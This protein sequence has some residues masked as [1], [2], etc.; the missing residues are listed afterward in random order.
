M[1]SPI[2]PTNDQ[3]S[4]LNEAS[5][6]MPENLQYKILDSNTIEINIIVPIYGVCIIE[7]QY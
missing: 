5:K 6:L 1:G 4:E 2:Y 7:L 3:L